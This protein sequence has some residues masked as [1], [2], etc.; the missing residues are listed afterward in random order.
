MNAMTMN[1]GMTATFMGPEVKGSRVTYR[2]DGGARTLMLSDDFVVPAA[3]A[4]HWQVVD[5]MGNETLLRR[6]VT[7]GDAFHKTIT[8]P[9]TVKDVAKVRIFCAYAEAVLGEAA[10]EKPMAM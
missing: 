9:A 6:L 3:P 2:M 4:P 10:F 7:I 5:S 1:Q 8:L